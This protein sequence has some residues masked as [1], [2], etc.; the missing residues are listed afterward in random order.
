MTTAYYATALGVLLLS[1][2]R[3][4]GDSYLPSKPEAF[5]F[6][7]GKHLVRIEPADSV[8]DSTYFWK[9]TEFNIFSYNQETENYERVAKFDVEGHPLHLCINDAG[10]RIVTIDQHFS[11]GYGQIAVVYDFKGKRLAQWTLKDLFGDEDLF[12][13]SKLP[14]FRR[15]TSMIFWRGSSVGWDHDQKTIW[16]SPPSTSVVHEDGSITDIHPDNMDS[17]EINLEKFEMK[18]IP[19]RNKKAEQAVAPSG[20]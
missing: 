14:N 6:H 19:P 8:K 4:F 17:Y 15:T 7:S 3:A 20:P 2:V 10:T 13:R 11:R 5:T 9:N 1:L 12:D 16:I 18:R